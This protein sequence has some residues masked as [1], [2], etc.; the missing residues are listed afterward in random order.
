MTSLSS[1]G[2]HS[3]TTKFASFIWEEFFSPL[4]TTGHVKLYP[5]EVDKKKNN[6]IT[7]NWDMNEN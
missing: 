7:P 6:K 5:E 4:Y 3:K 1:D 2:L